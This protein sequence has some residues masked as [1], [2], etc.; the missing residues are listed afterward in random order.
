VVEGEEVS[1]LELQ[2]WIQIYTYTDLSLPL[3]ALVHRTTLCTPLHSVALRCTCSPNSQV[4]ACSFCSEVYHPTQQCLGELYQ[5][6]S[7]FEAQWFGTME[8]CCPRCFVEA[9]W[10]VFIY[11]CCKV[12]SISSSSG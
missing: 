11:I 7:L 2:Q 10:V 1:G 9:R 6:I 5:H 8:W 12:G 3:S 4:L